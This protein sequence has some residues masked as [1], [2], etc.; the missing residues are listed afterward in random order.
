MVITRIPVLIGQGVPLFG[1]QRDDIRL[2]HE[3][4]RAFASGL[5]QSRY[6]VLP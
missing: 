2:R 5:V 1:P 6:A 3:E 4:T